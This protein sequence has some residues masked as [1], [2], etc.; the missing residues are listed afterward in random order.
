M[1]GVRAVIPIAGIAVANMMIVGIERDIGEQ[2]V[3]VVR[4]SARLMLDAVDDAGRRGGGERKREHDAQ[5]RANPPQRESNRNIHASQPIGVCAARQ[6]F[7]N[8]LQSII[9]RSASF[10]DSGAIDAQQSVEEG[11]GAGEPSHYRQMRRERSRSSLRRI[12]AMQAV[13]G[14]C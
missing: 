6:E 4:W 10:G 8:I 9:G 11:S 1:I 13:R 12:C 3:L 7:A 2:H 14:A 5:H